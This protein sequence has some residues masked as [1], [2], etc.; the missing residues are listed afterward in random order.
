[1]A[2]LILQLHNLLELRQELKATQ[3]P[4]RMK[5]PLRKGHIVK[6]EKKGDWHWANTLM[7]KRQISGCILIKYLKYLESKYNFSFFK[8]RLL[9]QMEYG[10]VILLMTPAFRINRLC[11]ISDN[12]KTITTQWRRCYNRNMPWSPSVLQ[13]DFYRMINHAGIFFTKKNTPF[14]PISLLKGNTKSTLINY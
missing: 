11:P 2:A 4:K 3:G 13:P 1:M 12:T 10:V 5:F 14:S 6:F 9:S 7:L 8:E